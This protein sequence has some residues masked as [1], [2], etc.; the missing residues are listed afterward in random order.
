MACELN[1]D[2]CNFDIEKAWVQSDLKGD[3]HLGLPQG[4]G[5][6]SGNIVRL[7]MRLYGLKQVSRQWHADLTRCLLVQGLLQCT[8]RRHPVFV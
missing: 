3:V 6:L 4:C 8:R 2:L 7:N 5:R 1:V